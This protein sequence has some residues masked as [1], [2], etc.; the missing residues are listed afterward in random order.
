MNHL[1]CIE[2]LNK[3]AGRKLSDDEVA[4]IFDRLNAKLGIK[5]GK[6]RPGKLTPAE[7]REAGNRAAADLEREAVE[8]ERKAADEVLRSDGGE[9]A[10]PV[11]G[12]GKP[13]SLVEA[14]QRLQETQATVA[15]A[16]ND[17]GIQPPAADAALIRQSETYEKAWRAISAC[18]QGRGL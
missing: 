9:V 3:A 14:E 15:K 1:K 13:E 7:I 8:H 6:P 4:A 17:A 16:A 18:V 5:A 11:G 12:E 10:A 2:R